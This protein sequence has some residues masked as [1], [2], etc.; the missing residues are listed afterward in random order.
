M[1]DLAQTDLRAVNLRV[2][3]LPH[4]SGIDAQHPRFSWNIRAQGRN[5]KQSAY[6][7]IVLSPSTPSSVIWDTNKILSSET[8]HIS[9]KGPPL[10]PQERYT[11]RVRM[12][13]EKG[14]ISSYASSW[15]E[16]GMLRQD[17]WEAKWIGQ[18]RG[19]EGATGEWGLQDPGPSEMAPSPAIFFRKVFDLKAPVSR[20]RLYAS[21]LG[22]Y[23]PFVNDRRV[24]ASLL[25]PGWTDYSKRI[26]YQTYD[27]TPYLHRGRNVLAMILGEGWYMGSVGF[28]TDK[29]RHHY[30][31]HPLII[32]QI[33]W[34][35]DE[36]HHGQVVSDS[37]WRYDDDGPIRY[38]DFLIGEYYDAR[39]EVS[40]WAGILF[41]DE[42]WEH[43]QEFVVS[44]VPL[45]GE[46]TFPV[47]ITME[48]PPQSIN[49]LSPLRQI[50]DFGQN[51]SGWVRLEVG[52][53][54]ATRL[55]LRFGEMLTQEQELYTANFRSAK[56][57][58][59]F[60]LQGEG[61]ESW[62]P[63]FTIHG[64]RYVE[65]SSTAADVHFEKIT[66]CVIHND[67]P[68]TG[69]FRCS[70]EM[71]NQLQ[72]NIE[73][74]QRSNF[75]SIPTD[76]PQRDE[77][78][79]WLADA[80]IF[81]RTAMFNMDVSSF[82][83]KWLDDVQDAQSP[84]GAFSVVAP[85]LVDEGDGAPGWGDG[86]IILP[87]AM[88]LTYGDKRIL[89]VFYP[90]MVKW[91]HY[92]GEV[93]PQYLWLNRRNHDFGD[94]LAVSEET[95]KDLIATAFWA[96]DACLVSGVAK[97]LGNSQDAR[98]Y[99]SLFRRI[100]KAF[101]EAFVRGD[102][103][104]VGNT[105]SAYALALFMHLIPRSLRHNSVQKLVSNIRDKGNHLST[106]FLGVSYLC[107]ALSMNGHDDMAYQL[108]LNTTYPSWGYPVIHGATTMW[109]RWN[110]WTRE[111]G[112]HP[113]DMNSFNHYAFG[114]IGE[115]LYR[116]VAGID[117]DPKQPGYRHIFI[118][119]HM[120][121]LEWVKAS[122]ESI[123]GQIAVF[124]KVQ[125][126]HVTLDVS[127]PANTTAT[128]YFPLSAT[129][130][131]F[132]NEVPVQKVAGVRGYR[133]SSRFGIIDIGS[134]SYHFVSGRQKDHV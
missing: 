33:E 100:Q 122:Y 97:I 78:L 87:W 26:I 115:W 71:V 95:P 73:W 131:I 7:I 74:S 102:G 91:L 14:L 88:Y 134:G 123:H 22:V 15:W 128:I 27:I 65:I 127:I 72:R 40:G 55:T 12:W 45:Y 8:T 110:G 133:S 120:G 81:A 41:D 118:R 76:C 25:T 105:Q 46:K 107:P 92:I 58:D 4:P 50:V 98:M 35:D 20:A 126:A 129:E 47:R 99:R 64:F 124:W 24:S 111:K 62:E 29:A 77:R 103:E 82:F 101:R 119:P 106:G 37:T 69:E 34:V 109:E 30:G 48:R 86:G 79:G 54:R 3:Y 80:H 132:E 19:E 31:R 84:Q 52:G 93:N 1:P 32:A 5:R 61:M 66:A 116:F 18:R 39:R 36:G 112:F 59:T 94:W 44:P 83:T 96:Y 63:H 130:G 117:T 75:V 49:Q 9:Y 70:N 113:S 16:T 42:S 85:R 90:S 53:T 2:E 28:R 114:S 11:W 121:S 10:R 104:I 56:N 51:M 6:Q 23:M 13:D 21:A 43:A 89:E 67:L 60:V 17:Q 57:T 68:R 125:G 38:S 108:L